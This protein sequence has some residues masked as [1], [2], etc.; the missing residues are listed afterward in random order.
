MEGQY[1]IKN[2]VLVTAGLVIGATVRGGRVVADPAEMTS[3]Y[4]L[5]RAFVPPSWNNFRSPISLVA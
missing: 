5:T 3:N 2:I 1:I 4:S